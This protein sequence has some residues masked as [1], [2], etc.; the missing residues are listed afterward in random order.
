MP[1]KCDLCCEVPALDSDVHMVVM[2]AS[3]VPPL[4]LCDRCFTVFMQELRPKAVA[5]EGGWTQWRIG[6]ADRPQS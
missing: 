4:F 2:P 1:R 3:E 5:R 6:V